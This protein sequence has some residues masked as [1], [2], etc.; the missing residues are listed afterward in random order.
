MLLTRCN[1]LNLPRIQMNLEVIWTLFNSV[2]V[3]SP[4]TKLT[5]PCAVLFC[6]IGPSSHSESAADRSA[7]SNETWMGD[8]GGRSPL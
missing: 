4:G 6:K 1:D 5:R 8:A 2:I 7:W 3:N